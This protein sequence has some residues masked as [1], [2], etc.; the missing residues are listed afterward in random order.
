MIF[1]FAGASQFSSQY[2]YK[3]FLHTIFSSLTFAVMV[4][5]ITVTSK[6]YANLPHEQLVDPINYVNKVLTESLAY[7]CN[8]YKVGQAPY[9][10]EAFLKA[11]L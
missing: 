5:L 3:S 10:I 1:P 4:Q 9:A 7:L 8:T 11:F 6:H 2:F